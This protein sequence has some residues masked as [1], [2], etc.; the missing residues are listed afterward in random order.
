MAPIST[1][2]APTVKRDAIKDF[3]VSVKF[4][5]LCPLIREYPPTVIGLAA[6]FPEWKPREAITRKSMVNGIRLFKLNK[7]EANVPL[8]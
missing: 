3:V 5:G 1:L 7:L 2:L 4:D 8:V 6:T